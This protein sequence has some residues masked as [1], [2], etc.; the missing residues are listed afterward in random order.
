V[1]AHRRTLR[2]PLLATGQLAL[3]LYVAHV[4][5]GLAPLEKLGH[6][7]QSVAFSVV[8]GAAF[9]VGA[10]GFSHFWRSAFTRGSLEMVMRRFAA[11]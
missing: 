8:W 1:H 2:A 3:T 4:A 5:I 7:R 11:G 9:C 10:V 6:G